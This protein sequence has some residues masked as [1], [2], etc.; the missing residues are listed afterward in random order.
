MYSGYLAGI[1][2]EPEFLNVWAANQVYIALGGL[3][4]AA[5]DMGIDTLTMEGYNAEILTEVLKLKEK[6]LVPVVLVALGYHTD[7]DYNAQLPKSR[8]ELENIF[9]YF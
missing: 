9:T 6:G 2:A 1:G 7:D 8:F 5:A 3:L 4:L